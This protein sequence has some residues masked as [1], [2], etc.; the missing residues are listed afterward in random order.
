MNDLEKCGRT[1]AGLYNNAQPLGM[2]YLHFTPEKMSREEA[3][4]L[5]TRVADIGF[6]Y[7]DYHRGRVVKTKVMADG[8]TSV[9]ALYDRDN[10]E[11]AQARAIADGL[12][13]PFYDGAFDTSAT[14]TKAARTRKKEV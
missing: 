13:D 12:A 2:G 11:G 4:A 7:F 8:S 10:G 14:E 1:I 9:A 6:G 3:L 5:A